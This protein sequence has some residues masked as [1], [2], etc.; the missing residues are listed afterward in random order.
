MVINLAAGIL[1]KLKQLKAV[2]QSDLIVSGKHMAVASLNCDLV[3][4]DQTLARVVEVSV[5]ESTRHSNRGNRTE[6]LHRIEHRC[7]CEA[8]D[9]SHR[10]ELTAAAVMGAGQSSTLA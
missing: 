10:T 6:S 9:V 2:D 7:V 8:G 5:T 1:R 4:I 3:A